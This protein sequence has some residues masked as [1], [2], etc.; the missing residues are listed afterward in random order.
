MKRIFLTLG[1]LSLLAFHSNGQTN[2]KGQKKVN[3]QNSTQNLSEEELN[4]FLR[5]NYERYPKEPVNSPQRKKKV[6]VK[7]DET[8]KTSLK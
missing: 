2:S 6:A 4:N 5:N 1:F 8:V 3:S 7:K